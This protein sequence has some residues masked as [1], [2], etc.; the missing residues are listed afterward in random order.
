MPAKKDWTQTFTEQ[1]TPWEE[2]ILLDA[3]T[4]KF[5]VRFLVK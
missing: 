2:K 3:S 5:K 4:D 1:G